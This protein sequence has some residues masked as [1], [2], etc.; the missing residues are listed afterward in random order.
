MG[1]SRADAY[2]HSLAT[3]D[4]LV[5]SEYTLLYCH[6]NI[7]SINQPSFAYLRRVYSIFNRKY[8]L[9][10]VTVSASSSHTRRYKKNLK[11]LYIV[12]SGFWVRMTLK[13]FKAF[14]SSKCDVDL[15][16]TVSNRC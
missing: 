12:G 9:V 8:V 16:K 3:L 15:F 13:L 10:L 5:E 4:K 6:A 7:P 1:V 2:G 14:V 11:K